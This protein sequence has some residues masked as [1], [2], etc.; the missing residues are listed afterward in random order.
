MKSILR[1]AVLN[2]L[3]ACAGTAAA[4]SGSLNEFQPQVM[5]VLVQVNS[6]GQITDVSPA[7][8]LSP[9]LNRLLRANLDEMINKPATDKNGRP[10][11]SQFIINLALQAGPLGNGNFDT[12]FAYV[13]TS[14]VPSGSWY[15]VHI[16]GH[17]LA[18]ARQG[19]YRPQQLRVPDQY[20]RNPSSYQRSHEHAKTPPK[21]NATQSSPTPPPVRDP[22]QGK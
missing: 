6:H 14:P 18:L 15:W 8:E 9:K 20:D 4:S 7:I 16:D 5:P 10:I 2:V 21:S 17:R 11:S 12:H 13:S 19:S 3:L 1:F 22:G